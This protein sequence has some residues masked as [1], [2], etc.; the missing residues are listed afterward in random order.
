MTD[1]Y[2]GLPLLL[3]TETR[4]GWLWA[5]NPQH[6]TLIHDYVA[7]T[8]RERA[9][10]V[11]HRAED[12]AHRPLADLDQARQ[13]PRR[14]AARYRPHPGWF[15]LSGQKGRGSKLRDLMQDHG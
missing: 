14:G 2:F 12:D 1:P 4:H 13:E 3:Q 7:A 10:L 5:Y 8:L 6:L 9:P 15:A 11:R